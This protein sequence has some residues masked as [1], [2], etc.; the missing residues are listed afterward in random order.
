MNAISLETGE[1]G[2][3]IEVQS[4]IMHSY[5]ISTMTLSQLGLAPKQ[6]NSAQDTGK[7]FCE[8]YAAH[9]FCQQVILLHLIIGKTMSQNTFA[10]YYTRL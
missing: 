4:E 2:F 1:E 9:G 10:G 3:E 8:Q 5:K 6:Q 7:P